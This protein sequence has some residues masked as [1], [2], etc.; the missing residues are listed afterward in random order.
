MY[1]VGVGL[2]RPGWLNVLGMPPRVN[3][4][5]STHR[6]RAMDFGRGPNLRTGPGRAPCVP[7]SR[8]HEERPA[9]GRKK[10]AEGRNEHIYMYIYTAGRPK[11]SHLDKRRGGQEGSVGLEDD[12]GHRREEVHAVQRRPARSLRH[13]FLVRGVRAERMNPASGGRGELMIKTHGGSF[14]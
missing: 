3:V 6:A 4:S 14:S 10:S 1:Y 12:V 2:R 11:R 5:F 8:G 9:A 13:Y 7:W